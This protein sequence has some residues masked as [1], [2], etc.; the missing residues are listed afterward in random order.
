[1]GGYSRGRRREKGAGS[2]GAIQVYWVSRWKENRAW[3]EVGELGS[4]AG[5]PRR[6]Q[7]SRLPPQQVEEKDRKLQSPSP[8][9][10]QPNSREVCPRNPTPSPGAPV[11]LPRRRVPARHLRALNSG[12]A[13]SP[14]P[15]LTS[16]RRE[17]PPLQPQPPRKRLP[18]PGGRRHSGALSSRGKPGRAPS[19]VHPPREPRAPRQ[20]RGRRPPARRPASSRAPAPPAPSLHCAPRRGSPTRCRA[21][22]VAWPPAARPSPDAPALRLLLRLLPR[23]CVRR[24]S[25]LQ[26]PRQVALATRRRRKSE[27]AGAPRFAVAPPEPWC[28]FLIP[29]WKGE[30]GAQSPGSPPRLRGRRESEG[31]MG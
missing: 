30:S 5:R 7:Q 31:E 8:P 21:A 14:P 10:S 17:H 25:A 16:A 26:E 2:P 27:R 20:S 22:T 29:A 4:G 11:E 9:H 18:M 1:M 12:A 6:K 28:S 19:W 15:R 24:P 3:T 23:R 13:A